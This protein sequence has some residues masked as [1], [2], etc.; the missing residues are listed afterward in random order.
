MQKYIQYLIGHLKMAAV[1]L[2][3]I[4]NVIKC[5]HCGDAIESKYFHD[6]VTCSCGCFRMNGDHDYL[7]RCFMN[8]KD[9]DYIDLSEYIEVDENNV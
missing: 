8:S 4:R 7:R 2:Q 9:I 3:N 1:L 6:F 5:K